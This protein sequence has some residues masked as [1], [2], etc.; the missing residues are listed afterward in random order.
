MDVTVDPCDDFHKH[1][2]GGGQECS[3]NPF[4]QMRTEAMNSLRAVLESQSVP[5]GDHTAIHKAVNM[6]RAC[7]RFPTDGL[8]L[9]LP[10]IRRFLASIGMNLTAA[11]KDRVEV[12]TENPMLPMLRLSLQYA[13]HTFVAFVVDG[14][15]AVNG[16]KILRVLVSN[17]DKEWLKDR[18]MLSEQEKKDYYAGVL[19]VYEEKPLL[20][21]IVMLIPDIA[22]FESQASRKL[23]SQ[24]RISN[25]RQEG[26][27]FN[28]EELAAY[29]NWYQPPDQWHAVLQR[30]SLLAYGVND[31]AHA[32][33]AG[34]ALLKLVTSPEQRSKA[35]QLMTW[36]LIRQLVG[37]GRNALLVTHSVSE[38]KDRCIRKVSEV[39]G[40]ALQGLLLL[41]TFTPQVIAQMET[42][43][44]MLL[45]ATAG[46]L[47]Q[48][49]PRFSSPL[50]DEATW[51]E[52]L[53]RLAAVD[54]VVGFP[55]RVRTESDLEEIYGGFPEANGIFWETWI[56]SA[57]IAQKRILKGVA[58]P[59]VQFPV[60]SAVASY[61]PSLNKLVVPAG[62][63]RPPVFMNNAPLVYHYG[64][65]GMIIARA[66]M[67]DGCAADAPGLD[68]A[69]RGSE[70]WRAA[71]ALSFYIRASKCSKYDPQTPFMD[72][73]YSAASL[74][75]D[76]EL[77]A[78]VAA[79]SASYE[80]FRRLPV[81][82]KNDFLTALPYTAEQLFF[83]ANC[84][85]RCCDP[86]KFRSDLTYDSDSFCEDTARLRVTSYQCNSIVKRI[87]EFSTAFNCPVG[88][89]MNPSDR[90]TS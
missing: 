3:G 54:V 44:G 55:D 87:P 56:L 12:T 23:K 42:I 2:C 69:A 24:D 41:K 13:L 5:E 77:I 59:D 73:A 58:T 43:S 50:P 38:L 75:G 8:A 84:A 9:E 22:N 26:L 45:N 51:L 25:S 89:K 81:S 40:S 61:T 28:L 67:R 83:V 85:M 20:P 33:S 14:L 63:A 66:I 16:K 70:N 27:F 71:V 57:G 72:Y 32:T 46:H 62:V 60:A 29:V 19:L 35:K 31:T 86:E 79:T 6:F 7:V 17:S 47:K 39:M 78:E 80:A 34:L 30:T 49:Q 88:S 36:S 15:H 10:R 4:L 74:L 52:A 64:T 37:F 18:A 76:P 53:G 82:A 48:K 21:E 65:V 90:C 68:D 1:V 11:A